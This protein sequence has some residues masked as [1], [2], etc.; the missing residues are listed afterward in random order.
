MNVKSA[1]LLVN[2]IVYRPGWTISATDHTNRYEGAIRVRIDYPAQSTTREEA[3]EGYPENIQT[4]AQF[5]IIVEDCPDET[6]LYRRI[7]DTILQ[8]EAHEAREYFRVQP[9]FWAPFHPHKIDGMKRW[10]EPDRDIVFG[11]G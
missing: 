8:I 3:E 10:G 1:L 9:T 2:Q 7:I 5:P 11:I 4:Y 6:A